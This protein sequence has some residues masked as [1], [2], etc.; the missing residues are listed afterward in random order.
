MRRADCTVHTKSVRCLSTNNATPPRRIN[1]ETTAQS[2]L[3]ILQP[4]STDDGAQ[5]VDSGLQYHVIYS[6]TLMIKH[7][8]R[9]T[10]PMPPFPAKSVL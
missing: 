9:M 7:E 6:A 3:T 4:R 2:A 5:T 1:D 10:C 8:L